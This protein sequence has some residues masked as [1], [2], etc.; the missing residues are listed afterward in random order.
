M[1]IKPIKLD[2]SHPHAPLAVQLN[3]FKK[4]AWHKI[5]WQWVG[6]IGGVILGAAHG[7]KLNAFL[8]QVSGEPGNMWVAMGIASV[9]MGGF[10]LAA[11]VYIL[12][13]GHDKQEAVLIDTMAKLRA[14]DPML[15]DVFVQIEEQLEHASHVWIDHC[16]SVLQSYPLTT[17]HVG[18]EPCSGAD[19]SQHCATKSVVI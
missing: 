5:P 18:V 3:H 4:R 2:P 12:N 14:N 11:G 13:I 19:E 9:L 10:L 16:L 17:T 8:T 7:Y 15:N 1:T 6:G